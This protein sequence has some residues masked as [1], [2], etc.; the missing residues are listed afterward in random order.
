M[1]AMTRFQQLFPNTTAILFDLGGVVL[2]VDYQRT[3]TAFEALG[4]THFSE[5]YSQARQT[6]LFDRLETGR[7]SPEAFRAQIRQLAPSLALSDAQIDG[8]WNAM[9]LD[10]PAERLQLLRSLKTQY[11]TFL[12]SNTNAIH[13]GALSNYL[14]KTFGISSLRPC[15]EGV[16]YSSDI[17]LRK[18]DSP[19]FE[20]V[21][22]QNSLS[23]HTTVFIDDLPQNIAGAQQVGLCTRHLTGG[24]TLLDLFG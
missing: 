22:T 20:Y 15:F 2:N 5:I 23:P 18:P 16:Y 7:L 19:C 13:L 8:A 21:L 24:E 9:L 14:Q 12:L 11:R 1:L 17:G 4:I 10:L 6:G 3:Q